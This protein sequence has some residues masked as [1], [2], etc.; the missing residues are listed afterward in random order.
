M[1]DHAA[2][3][4][5]QE[6]V[7]PET[8]EK[9]A[10]IREECEGSLNKFLVRMWPIIE[11]GVDYVDGWHIGCV[12]AHLE[13]FYYGEIPKLI[14]NIP[15]RHCKSILACVAFFCWGWAKNPASRWLFASYDLPNVIRDSLKCRDVIVSQWYQEL[16]GDRVVLKKDQR[17]KRRMLNT[18][19]G[20]RLSTYVGTSGATGD[21][22]DYIIADDPIS[23]G[24][25][26]RA[27]ER[28]KC[29]DW[30]TRTMVTRI[31]NPNKV[32]RLIIQQRLNRGDL[33]GCM[34]GADLGYETLILP[35]HAERKRIFLPSP[36]AIPP[37]DP[38]IPTKLQQ[39]VA[40][41]YDNRP[42]GVALWPER[43][44]PEAI[45]EW[46]RELRSAAPGQLYQRPTE[47]DG[48]IFKDGHFRVCWPEFG[49]DGTV[50]VLKQVVGGESFIRKV[51]VK[52][53]EWFQCCDTA[54]EIN[55]KNDFTAVGT[56]GL[57]PTGEL[58][59]FDMFCERL[60]VPDQ[61]PVI[62]ALRTGRVI[63]DKN[64]KKIIGSP[65]EMPWPFEV[66]WQGIEPKASGIGVIQ[67]GRRLNIF[68]RKLAVKDQGKVSRAAPVLTMY[69][70]GSVY[71]LERGAWRTDTESELKDFP[72]GAHDD[73][74]LTGDSVVETESGGKPIRDVVAGEM[75][76]TRCGLRR[77]LASEMTG[78]N[79]EVYRVEF[80][81]GSHI[82]ATA[83]HPIFVKDRGFVCVD[84]LSYADEVT[85]WQNHLSKLSSS[86]VEL[87][88][89]TRIPSVA[90][91][92]FTSS[93]TTN[94]SRH[95]GTITGTCGSIITG[96]KFPTDTTF[97]T[98]T[99]IRSTMSRRTLFVS[100]NKNIDGLKKNAGHSGRNQTGSTWNVSGG[101]LRLGIGANGEG[102]NIPS[103]PRRF[104][105]QE[106]RNAFLN[107]SVSS[108]GVNSGRFGRMPCF[109]GMRV[110]PDTDGIPVLTTKTERVQV[111]E[112]HSG[113]I[114]IQKPKPVPV[115]VRA[116]RYLGRRKV[117]NLTVEGEHEY[118]AN[119]IL[120]HN[121]DVIA[122]AGIY[123]AKRA[124]DNDA[125]TT[126]RDIVYT[127]DGVP[128][129]EPVDDP[130]AANM[131]KIWGH[132]MSK[133]PDEPKTD[134]EKDVEGEMKT[135][136]A[137]S[138]LDSVL[139][140]LFEGEQGRRKATTE[141]KDFAAVM[142]R[143]PDEP[144]EIGSAMKD[145]L[146]LMGD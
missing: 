83:S 63:W 94:G 9:L 110:W 51:A 27:V 135:P 15:P 97:T 47:E 38:I 105:S 141:K 92:G 117:Y 41:L 114:G 85:T 34:M 86:T 127:D 4:V 107:A 91:T 113:L 145:I 28:L 84:A 115:V 5:E 60:E 140:D 102:R 13:A 139:S 44:Q 29:L 118:F 143:K 2:G 134:T 16:W 142:N 104:G 36:G 79:S 61:L 14:I 132:L 55:Q 137:Q 109:A 123:A 144:E 138:L 57:T 8:E 70:D 74:C 125:V 35:I 25:A 6:T 66:D 133:K 122:Y 89:D 23:A 116:V 90:N 81:D 54:F 1:L 129:A 62:F 131:A 33:S 99:G 82:D 42:D 37:R 73:R 18:A 101:R 52:D 11:P 3:M 103:S 20:Q 30:W 59:I 17:A 67:A 106:N 111:A 32:R 49:K 130:A 100:A 95:R 68:F 120:T 39:R 119:G 7:D 12:A 50:I 65:E 40:E 88:V 43:F 46:K 26:E 76:W 31:N 128:M 77:V 24:K 93:V 19:M 126:D 69:E 124:T 80:S 78:E 112:N 71:H 48:A 10:K 98:T 75:V 58:I 45:A 108:A 121:C 136:K 72:N 21:G 22:G 96:R 64:E 87:T 53:C 146:D 56:F